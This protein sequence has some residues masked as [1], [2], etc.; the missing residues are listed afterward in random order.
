MRKIIRALRRAF[1]RT[2]LGLPHVHT[3]TLFG[4]RSSIAK[5]FCAGPFSYVSGGCFIAPGVTLGMYS[6]I[7]PRVQILGNDHV[8]DRPG[9]PII[10]S[11]RPKF[12][13]TKIGADVWIG[14]N[15]VVMCGVTIGE[16]SIV[17]SGSVVTK[18]VAPFTVVGGVPARVIKT[19]FS[20]QEQDA[21]RDMLRQQPR[22]GRYCESIKI[23]NP[24]A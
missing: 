11:G 17:G 15:C 1:W 9:I 21:H 7:G 5:D 16:G 10:F 12:M 4:G 2:I 20:P 14:A 24:N 19:R 23:R 8:F 18:D 13:P 3:T 22:G 6:M